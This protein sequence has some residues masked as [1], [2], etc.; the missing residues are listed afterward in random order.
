MGECGCFNDDSM[1]RFDGPDGFVYGIEI[2]L[3]CRYCDAAP[4][5]VIRRY[6]DND[7]GRQWVE[8]AEPAP[9]L[10]YSEDGAGFFAIPLIDTAL[11]IQA[12]K[13]ELGPAVAIDGDV[14]DVET[15]SEELRNAC[16]EAISNTV[17][18]WQSKRG[19]QHG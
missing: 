11:I 13:K 1:F 4:S 10:N 14:V 2:N 6:V 15:L 16:A 3:G 8:S 12:I 5:V 18:A 9:F 7:E 19:A 17:R